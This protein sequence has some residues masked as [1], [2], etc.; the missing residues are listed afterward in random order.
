MTVIQK[1]LIFKLD[2]ATYT[3]KFPN[4]GE[5]MDIENMRIALTNGA[6]TDMLRTGLKSAHFAVDLVDAMSILYVLAP[7]LRTDLSVSNYNDLDLFLAKKVV[8]AYKEQIKPWF[9]K[10]MDELLKDEDVPAPLVSKKKADANEAEEAGS[11]V[12]L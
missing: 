7:T 1:T 4:V 3:L 12:N 8:K 10:I 9:D 2:S 11:T 6:Y 5:Y